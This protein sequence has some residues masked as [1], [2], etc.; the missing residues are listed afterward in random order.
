M[1]RNLFCQHARHDLSSRR[2][3]IFHPFTESPKGSTSGRSSNTFRA[4]TLNP[5]KGSFHHPNSQ[6]RIRF[7]FGETNFNMFLNGVENVPTHHRSLKMVLNNRHMKKQILTCE[8][9]TE[10]DSIR[11]SA[12]TSSKATHTK[13]VNI[14][15][16]C[17]GSARRSLNDFALYCIF[18]DFFSILVRWCKNKKHFFSA[19]RVWDAIPWKAL[20]LIG[21]RRRE[22]LINLAR[23][24]CCGI[25]ASRDKRSRRGRRREWDIK[26]NWFSS[27]FVLP[28]NNKGVVPSESSERIFFFFEKAENTDNVGSIVD[29]ES[30]EQ[31]GH[32]LCSHD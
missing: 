2:R 28:I 30:T 12:K 26:N 20:D 18:N 25:I 32:R 10:T 16:V 11:L 15:R 23:S 22:K 9:P 6:R 21:S 19:T 5:F 27:T 14:F 4:F 1:C 17:R 8:R 24:I 29:I 7:C 3:F 13:I 31:T